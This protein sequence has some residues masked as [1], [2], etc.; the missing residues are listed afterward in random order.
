MRKHSQSFFLLVMMEVTVGCSLLRSSPFDQSLE[1]QLT[2]GVSFGQFAR[3]P[4]GHIGQIVKVGGEV[5]RQRVLWTGR[6]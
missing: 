1:A 6:K 4:S 2:I 3:D 5:L